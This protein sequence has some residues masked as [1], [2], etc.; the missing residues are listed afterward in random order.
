MT[1]WIAS[2]E[3]IDEKLALLD[4]TT[5]KKFVAVVRRNEHMFLYPCS[6]FS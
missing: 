3:Q 5:F 6:Q 4:L 1:S 2:M